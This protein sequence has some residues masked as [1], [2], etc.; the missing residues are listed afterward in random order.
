MPTDARS[1]VREL[2]RRRGDE[3]W[4]VEANTDATLFALS[5][6]GWKLVPVDEGTSRSGG[7]PCPAPS[8]ASQP[9]PVSRDDVSGDRGAPANSALGPEG[10]P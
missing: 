10:R 5:Q 6:A 4:Q 9:T 8:R 3:D 2:V 7:R 1:I